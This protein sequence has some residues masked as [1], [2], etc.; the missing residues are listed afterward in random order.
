MLGL[1]IQIY[2]LAAPYTKVEESFNVQALHDILTHGIP[3]RNF[4][5]FFRANYDHFTFPGSVPRTFVGAV[6]LSGLLSPLTFFLDPN[7]SDNA[8]FQLLGIL[9]RRAV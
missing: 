8:R 4:I 1:L 7:Q 9:F 5:P 3:T 2:H 6:T